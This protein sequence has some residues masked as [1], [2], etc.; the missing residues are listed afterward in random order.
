MIRI[1]NTASRNTLATIVAGTVG[2]TA[3]MPAGAADSLTVTVNANVIGVCKFFNGPY[4]ITIA[5]S[6]TD[7]DPSLSTTATGTAN[8][9]YRCS[10]GQNPTFSLPASVTLTGAGS[11]DAT[12]TY[13][14]GGAGTGMGAGQAKTLAVTG[15]I[16][17][18]D[19]QNKSVGAYS[20][21][22]TVSI[23]P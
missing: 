10:N 1:L 9:E 19:F 15:T 22:I 4:S 2:L 17:E 7:I 8:I 6:G 16:A 12:I 20:N 11:M 23:S 5:N 13:T 3:V 21:T 18:A 14:G